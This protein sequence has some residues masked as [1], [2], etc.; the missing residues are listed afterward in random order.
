MSTALRPAGFRQP[1]VFRAVE[2]ALEAVAR[3]RRLA[4]LLIGLLPIAVRVAQLPWAPAPEPVQH[5]E[6]SYLLA[7]DTFASGRLTNPPHALPWH[8]EAFHIIQRPTYASKYP[9]AQGLILALGQYLTG[10]PF[11]GVL[12]SVG[13]MCGA[14]CWML[15]GWVSPGWALL[16]GFLGAAKYSIH[17][18]WIDSYWGG[19]MAGL[20]GALVLGA[21]PRLLR[22]PRPGAGI[23]LGLGLAMLANSRPYEGLLLCFPIAVV[24]GR[25]Y[26]KDSKPVKASDVRKA[27]IPVI[28]ILVITTGLSAFYNYRVTGKPLTTPYTVHERAYMPVPPFL[29]Q[30]LPPFPDYHNPTMRKFGLQLVE[31]FNQQRSW[32]SVGRRLLEIWELPHGL[33]FSEEIRENPA[34]I[35]FPLN[36]AGLL[37]AL[38]MLRSRRMR[39]ATICFA[40]VTAGMLATSWYLEHYSAPIAAL[41]ILLWVE[42]LRLLA[43]QRHVPLAV[44]IGR[45][46]PV[47]VAA[48]L[49][50]YLVR[51]PLRIPSITGIQI[52]R[53]RIT[54]ELERLPG[55]QL[56]IV[57]Y[58]RNHDP[59]IEWVYNRADIDGAK[60][61]WARYLT[62]PE[63][64]AL[65][66]YYSGRTV[67]LLDPDRVPVR[68]IPFR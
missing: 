14:I 24:L 34:V 17:H 66:Q 44:W 21:L 63:N 8:F 36:A 18:Y 4:V 43:A 27:C 25:V 30:H 31:A 40:L 16:G 26:F 23:V 45:C 10:Q 11:A 48:Y 19:A 58:Q 61:V 51:T 39:V 12:V 2:G 42:F 37:A 49:A 57:R 62:P 65:L 15:Q 29:W 55:K 64:L 38:W 5:D 56:V 6:F 33:D 13:L 50:I 54:A 52:D 41:R 53:P 7:A 20:G 9:P 28:V 46:V 67:W 68:P 59:N 35:W 22:R 1:S 47:A 32:H 60:I 3:R